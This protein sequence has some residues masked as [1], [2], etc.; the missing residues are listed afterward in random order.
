MQITN[1]LIWQIDSTLRNLELKENKVN[2]ITGDS[3]KGKSSILAIIDYCLLSSSSDGISKTNVDNF[4]NW[5]GIRLSINGKYFT[6]CRKATHFEEDDLVYFDKNGDIPQIP[7][8]N[9]KKDVLKEHLNYEFGIN[10]SLKIPYGGRFIQQG[11]KV[12]YRYFIPHCFIDQTTLT[13]SEHLYSKISDLKT[14]E[15]IDRTFDMA[16][17]SENAETMIMRTRLEE[18]QRNLARIEYKQS[19]SKDSYFNFESEIESLYDR[20]CYFGLISEN[21]KNEPTVSDKLENLKAIVNYK[22]IN[23]I[24]AINERTKIEKELFLLKK[25]LTDINEYIETNTEYKKFLKDNQDSLLIAKYLDDNYS[26][27]LYT[28]NIYSIIKSLLNQ[29]SEIKKAIAE[30]GQNSLI[31]KTNAKRKELELKI[32]SL[33]KKLTTV[34][35]EKITPIELYRFMG[36]L[37]SEI[38]RIVVLPKYDYTDTIEKITTKIDELE[39]KI[40]DNNAFKEYTLSLLNGKIKEIFTRM[41]LKGFEDATPIFNKAKKTL[42]LINKNQ[43]EKMIDIGS[44]SNYMY[45]HVA[46]FLALHELV[47]DR[48]VPWV[49]RFLVIDQP[50]TP[51]FSTAG[52][53]TDDFA[54]LDAALNEINSFVEK[55]RSHGGFQIILLEHIEESYWLDREM[56]NFTLVDNELRG[57]YGLIHFK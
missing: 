43:V 40:T 52:K 2:V 28:K 23:E 10:S 55:M 48:N 54:S 3:G 42:D 15:R 31:S 1:I 16:L 36:E 19:A 51:Y 21:R 9:I 33:S 57:N 7:I 12:S 25:E 35:D 34:S 56:T 47:R 39:S 44:A 26:E 6:I 27:I 30:K 17:G 45:V 14:R 18:L 5:Y 13:S 22:D 37:S 8:N 46:Y 29:S 49:P 50:S 53:K 24:P 11:S 38:K 20:A 41:P 32:S 4:V